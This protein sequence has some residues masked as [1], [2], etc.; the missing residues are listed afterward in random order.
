MSDSIAS[1]NGTSS[2]ANSHRAGWSPH[3]LSSR[4]TCLDSCKAERPC[5]YDVA[6][7]AFIMPEPFRRGDVCSTRT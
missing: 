1:I 7:H 3:R 5:I 2:G 4:A 6:R